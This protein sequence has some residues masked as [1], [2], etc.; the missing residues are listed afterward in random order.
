MAPEDE[1]PPPT[2]NVWW[3]SCENPQKK[4]SKIITFI[5]P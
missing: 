2:P 1:L 5:M 3:W 4:D